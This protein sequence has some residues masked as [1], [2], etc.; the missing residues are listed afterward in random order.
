M[1]RKKSRAPII[2]LLVLAVAAFCG[3]FLSYYHYNGEV[4]AYENSVADT[5]AFFTSHI[6]QPFVNS[7]VH[8]EPYIYYNHRDDALFFFDAPEGFTLVSHSEAWNQDMLELL[9]HEL[10]KNEHG[11]EIDLLYE[12]I[13]YP[14]DE[15]DEERIA[16]TFTLGVKSVSF[17]FQF[18]A[19]PADFTVDFPQEIGTIA[20][21]S[22]DKNTTIESMAGSLSHEYGHLY[23]RYYMFDSMIS[24]NDSLQ[25]TE[26]ARLRNATGHNLITN[27]GPGSTYWQE[28]H[29]YLIEIAAEDYVQ[30]MGSPTSIQIVDYLDVQQILNGAEAPTS[31]VGARNAFPQENM[32][33]PLANDVPGLTDYFYSFIDTAPRIPIEEK[34][35]ISLQI[36]QRPVQHN[37]VDGLRTFTHY[38]ITWNAP[39]QNA[40][41]TLACYEPD[42]YIGWGIPIKTVHPGQNTSAVIGE[43]VVERGDRVVFMD[44]GNAHGVKVFFVVALLPDGTFYISDKLEY[45]FH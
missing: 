45:H 5:E 19:F 30:L 27:A 41:Y 3:G 44:D 26:Y 9:Y 13:V 23:T 25:E 7:A 16:A 38:V 36:Q 29:R 43:Y 42:D 33:I 22:G 11:D 21:Y 20:L 37:L 40:I 4:E 10:L 12:V 34:K 2:I 18:P 17:F 24:V 8:N 32:M 6:P 15:E 1:K 35:D 39:Y 28:R 31:W 14:Y